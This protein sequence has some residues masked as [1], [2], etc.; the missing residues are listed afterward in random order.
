MFW[1]LLSMVTV[2]MM[3]GTSLAFMGRLQTR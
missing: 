3:A 1:I 2:L